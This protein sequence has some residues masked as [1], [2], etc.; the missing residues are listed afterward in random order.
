MDTTAASRIWKKI[1]ML[2]D[3][4]R[5]SGMGI[6][7]RQGNVAVLWHITQMCGLGPS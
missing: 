4:C 5:A 1:M 3:T 7:F 6:F 2:P